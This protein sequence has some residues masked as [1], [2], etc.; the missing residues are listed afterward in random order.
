M[1]ATA[2]TASSNRGVAWKHVLTGALVVLVIG[3][4]ANLLGWNIRGWLHDVWHTVTS[5]SAGYVVAGIA[6]KTVQTVAAAFAW[7]AIL[8]F[9][10]PGRVRWLDILA[11]YAASVALNNVV[12]ANL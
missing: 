3:A 10:Y 12:P 9:A 4:L 7:Y 2:A 6:F 11:C 1:G 8:R 5:I